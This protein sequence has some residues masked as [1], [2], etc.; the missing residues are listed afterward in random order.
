MKCPL[1]DGD[2][3]D[4]RDS[5]DG[6]DLEVVT[7]RCIYCNRGKTSLWKWIR[8]MLIRPK[9]KYTKISYDYRSKYKQ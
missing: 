9:Y 7:F 3:Y 4:E 2:W 1:C 6:I 5:E 8:Y